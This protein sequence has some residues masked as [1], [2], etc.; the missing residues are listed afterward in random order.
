MK[1]ETRRAEKVVHD[2]LA[3]RGASWVYPDLAAGMVD[4][5]RRTGEYFR[6]TNAEIKLW[7]TESLTPLTSRLY[8]K[9]L[10]PVVK[11]DDLTAE[12]VETA[13][14][15]KKASKLSP[16]AIHKIREPSVVDVVRAFQKLEK[17]V[18]QEQ[19]PQTTNRRSGRKRQKTGRSYNA[20]TEIAAQLKALRKALK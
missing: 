13:A 2:Y 12:A 7:F 15:R 16:A 10:S 4:V 20:D 19:E 1:I 11:Y 9:F 18:A 17:A 3:D 5:S 8:T 14:Q 6:A